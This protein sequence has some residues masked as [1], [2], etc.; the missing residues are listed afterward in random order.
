MYKYR[1]RPFPL[2]VAFGG[3]SLLFNFLASPPIDMSLTLKETPQIQ[4]LT[5]YILSDDD[6]VE[7]PRHN[8]LKLKC[9]IICI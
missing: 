6:Y 1:T 7:I 3:G 4:M 8:A 5:D 9:F 2:Q